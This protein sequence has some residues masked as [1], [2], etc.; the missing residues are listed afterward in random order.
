M[1]L[2]LMNQERRL[3]EAEAAGKLP[4]GRSSPLRG[5]R[6]TSPVRKPAPLP[7]LGRFSLQSQYLL[8]A[9]M[10]LAALLVFAGAMLYHA[11]KMND[12]ATQIEKA[13]EMQM[14]SQRIVKAG[15]QAVQGN[16]DG[17]DQ[18]R[19]SRRTFEADLNGLMHGSSEIPASGGTALQILSGIETQW[20]L[21]NGEIDTVLR[22]MDTVLDQNRRIA[23]NDA[24]SERL[25]E[26]TEQAATNLLQTHV[27]PNPAA[28]VTA[29][30]QLIAHMARNNG[31]APDDVAIQQGVARISNHLHAVAANVN[32]IVTA[33]RAAQD[34]FANADKLLSAARVLG[35]DYERQRTA[36]DLY[37]MIAALACL[38]ML[39]STGLL[40]WIN[41]HEARRQAW[42]I[43]KE[44]ER[45]Q[46]AILR[47]LSEIAAFADGDLTARATVTDEITG[48]IADSV[49]YTIEELRNLVIGINTATDQVAQASSNAQ[50]ISTELLAA[51]QK[52]SQVIHN[53]NASVKEMARSINEVS[54]NANESAQVA[55]QS[56]E[57][58]GKGAV[59]VQDSINGMNEIRRQ[60]QETAKRIKRLGENS[61]EISEIVEL[62][63]DI[64]EQT[65]I[66]ALNAAIQ[67]ASAGEAGRGFSVVA[68]E[69]QRLAER[70]AEATKQI[71]AIVK[72]IQSDTQD[73]VSAMEQSTHGVVEGTKR[74]D[75]AGQA[76]KEIGDVSNTLF[77]LIEAISRATRAQAQSAELVAGSMQEILQINTRTTEGTQQTAQ[78]IGELSLMAATLRNSVSGF[79][80]T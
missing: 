72:T 58:A 49:N 15:Q 12:I 24:S 29:A 23:N 21:I 46:Q 50:A 71:G 65:N 39:V 3:P 7:L 70:S 18:L 77:T 54:V 35:S 61:Q 22:Q 69:V 74:S 60:I 47:L 16:N 14:L 42:Q 76:L 75:A 25:L 80:L 59:A 44:N 9:S 48:A 57:V 2:K 10:L 78:S 79:K 38:L 19:T 43:E 30:L 63:A 68:E 62:I 8:A 64:T 51:A 45:N 66:L 73:A 11:K 5:R 34:L 13:T 52:Q 20:R 4:E 31:T 6:M 17:F 36:L 53:T 41:V 26:L 67:A 27:L 28:A 55:R 33:K 37:R 32:N 1:P 56:L 40:A